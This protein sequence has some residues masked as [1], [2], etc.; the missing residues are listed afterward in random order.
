MRLPCTVL[1]LTLAAAPLAGDAVDDYVRA[2]VA[3]QK[4]PGLS[5]C[6]TR[7][8]KV[9]KAQGYGLANVEH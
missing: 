5:L 3:R 2:Q 4:I 8:G 7:D 1:L 6:V 9:V